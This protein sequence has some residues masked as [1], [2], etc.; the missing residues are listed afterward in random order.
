MPHEKIQGLETKLGYSFKDQ[1]LLIQ[2]LTHK[3]FANEYRS[4]S[5]GHNERLEFLGDTVLDFL[6]SDILMRLCP[7]SQEGELSKLRAVIVSEP[8]LSETAR[9]L[10][11]G[12]HLLLGKGEEQTG[13]REKSSLLANAV[14]A[15]I[16]AI[17]LDGGL[18]DAYRFIRDN[19]EPQI[20]ALVANGLTHDYKTDL[21]EQCQSIFG[22]LP[23][24]TVVGE[25]GPD[26]QKLFEVEIFAGGSAL[27]R[28]VGKSK[29]EAE[30][31]AA[32][33]ALERLKKP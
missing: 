19:F 5:S 13:G 29:K 12:V 23:K 31:M 14:E 18:E 15:V 1:T 28:G 32:K 25:S 17:Y 3:S 26:H 6:V 2:A 10:D 27:G 24:Y 8:N 20:K 30:Q 22:A 4:E 21:Q 7:E 11:F 16:A 33:E 9:A